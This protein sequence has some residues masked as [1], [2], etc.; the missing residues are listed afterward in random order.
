MCAP[1]LP[2]WLSARSLGSLSSSEAALRLARQRL[3][4]A[5]QQLN[6]AQRAFRS[7]ETGLF[8]L[9]RVRQLWLEAAGAEARAAL[10]Q[11]AS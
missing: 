4:V 1:A 3:A 2:V 9:Y 10:A 11:P 8:D 6:V 7:G 5:D